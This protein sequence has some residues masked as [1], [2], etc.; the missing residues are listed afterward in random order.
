MATKPSVRPK[1]RSKQLEKPMGEP[2]EKRT[3]KFE[4]R[5]GIQ[6]YYPA[7]HI[8]FAHT[9]VWPKLWLPPMQT[10]A[11]LHLNGNDLQS[12]NDIKKWIENINNFEDMIKTLLRLPHNQFWSTLV[13]EKSLQISLESYLKFAPRSHDMTTSLL[14]DQ[15]KLVLKRVFHLVFKL[16]YRICSVVE[17]NAH[18]ISENTFGSLIYDNYLIDVPKIID[19]SSLYVNTCYHQILTQ[20]L[21][22]VIRCQPRYEDDLF[23]SCS[24]FVDIFHSIEQRL[25]IDENQ[26]ETNDRLSYCQWTELQTIISIIVVTSDNLRVLIQTFPLMSDLYKRSSID[27]TIAEFYNRVFSNLQNELKR[28]FELFSGN[29]IQIGDRIQRQLLRA[30]S[31]LIATFRSIIETSFLNKFTNESINNETKLSLI[32]QLIEM[33]T[34]ASYEKCF[35]SDYCNVYDIDKDLEMLSSSSNLTLFK[36]LDK[37]RLD[38]LKSV[39]KNSTFRST[40]AQNNTN[41]NTTFVCNN[42]VDSRSNGF[43][44]YELDI[45]LESQI[46]Y[47]REIIPDLGPGFVHKCLLFYNMDNEKALNAILEDTLPPQLVSLDR[48]MQKIVKPESDKS[49]DK[50]PDNDNNI[51][52]NQRQLTCNN[53]FVSQLPK[54]IENRDNI[55]NGD[56]FDIFRNKSVDLSRIHLGKKDNKITKVDDTTKDK[57]ITLH[58]MALEEEQILEEMGYN[59]EYDDTYEDDTIDLISDKLMDE[60]Q[61]NDDKNDT[62]D[63]NISD[64]NKS[65]SYNRNNKNREMSRNNHNY[66]NRK[67]K[68]NFR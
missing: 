51:A 1:V 53:E 2:L 68:Q 62:N 47:I 21:S 35:I 65:H 29:E 57:I 63:D 12:N 60:L 36:S 4:D 46:Q 39:I 18:F 58:H 43:E 33:L 66:Y 55:Y 67:P 44:N 17:S 9:M 50:K 49:K 56:E 7:L 15:M 28:R 5:D 24:N 31:Q 32:D 13:Y 48:N 23:Q 41:I 45:E 30:R 10:I 37:T 16:Y 3:I 19:L 42:E 27:K 38:Y 14:T 8:K 40:K 61:A 20:M 25:G 52:K 59:D 6:R 64:N 22:N 34:M 54:L 26:F 11:A